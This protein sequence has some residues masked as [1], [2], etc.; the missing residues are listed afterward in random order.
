MENLRAENG[1][2]PDLKKKNRYIHI[3]NNIT[4]KYMI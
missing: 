2:K 4:L 3:F 1:M